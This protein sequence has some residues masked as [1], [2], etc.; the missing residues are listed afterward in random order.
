[1]ARLVDL[2][3]VVV[4]RGGRGQSFVYE[5]V[6]AGEGAD[7]ARF[8]PGLI[9]LSRAAASRTTADRSGQNGRWSAH[10][11]ERSGSS[12][13]RI[14]P[15]SGRGR[16]EVSSRNGSGSSDLPATNGHDP[17]ISRLGLAAK[18]RRRP[19]RDRRA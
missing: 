3:Y 6:Y 16:S 18:S 8:V 9:D 19:L 7:G 4:H 10:E 17:E 12:R 11:G 14:G 2:E 15:E 13:G 1:M 5:L